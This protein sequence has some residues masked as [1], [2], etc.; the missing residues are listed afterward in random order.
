MDTFTLTSI[1]LT[2]GFISL[3]LLL[4]LRQRTKQRRAVA[5]NQEQ[6]NRDKTVTAED[7]AYAENFFCFMLTN[8]TCRSGFKIGPSKWAPDVRTPG[9]TL[10]SE[11]RL[12]DGLPQLEERVHPS[13]D[14]RS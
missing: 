3:G 1:P 6:T 5:I 14:L 13:E 12:N 10:P 7:R 11:S 4:Y 2:L 9:E 8:G